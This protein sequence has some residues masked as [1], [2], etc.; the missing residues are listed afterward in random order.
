MSIRI[1][2]IWHNKIFDDLVHIPPS[3]YSKLIWFGV[4]EKYPKEYNQQRGYNIVMEKDLS[5]YRPDLQEKGYCQTSCMYHCFKNRL[6]DDV[7]FVGF[8]QYD[9]FIP[10]DFFDRLNNKLDQYRGQNKIPILSLLNFT[11][12]Q[13]L[14]WCTGMCDDHPLAALPHYNA[15]FGT[16]YTKE[17]IMQANA[18]LPY[19]HTFVIPKS[20]FDRM[21][22]WIC[23]YIQDIEDS[24]TWPSSFSTCE[25][26]ERCHGLFLALEQMRDP[27]HVV[28]ASLDLQHHQQYKHRLV[29]GVG[30][31]NEQFMKS[32]S[33]C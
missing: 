4:N 12:E 8:L 30:G 21:M 15:F 24:G 31:W 10:S 3:Q 23:K 6:C 27:D 7:E 19:L 32:S 33:Q 29:D 17:D 16:S 18:L 25:F 22:A 14:V 26:M 28:L 1:F 13:T 20:M 9:L 11:L 5:H 2:N